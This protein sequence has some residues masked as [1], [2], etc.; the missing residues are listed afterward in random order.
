MRDSSPGEEGVFPY[1]LKGGLEIKQMIVDLVQFM[2]SNSAE[3]WEESLKVGVIVPLFKKGDRDNPGNYRGV[4]LLPMARRILSRVLA[5][6]LRIWAEELI[7]LDDEQ[8]GFRKI[9]S[10]ADA[11]QI[12]LWL[13]EDTLDLRRRMEAAGVEVNDA[14]SPSA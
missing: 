1:L 4:C 7:L 2:F 8:A 3:Q 5:E 9:R 11:S 10:T 6:R 12:M 13:H 14:C